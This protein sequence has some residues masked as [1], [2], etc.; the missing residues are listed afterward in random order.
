MST[1]EIIN[2]STGKIYPEFLPPTGEITSTLNITSPNNEYQITLEQ[3]ND[4][5]AYIFSYTTDDTEKPGNLQ[6]RNINDGN[7][8]LMTGNS[9][10]TMS[11]DNASNVLINTAPNNGNLAFTTEVEFQNGIVLSSNNT[12]TQI[13]QN[14]DNLSIVAGGTINFTTNNKT[15]II[16]TDGT[17]N[18]EGLTLGTSN[19]EVTYGT[20]DIQLVSTAGEFNVTDK[21]NTGQIYDTHFNPPPRAIYEQGTTQT[22]SSL[23]T[24]VYNYTP[25]TTGLYVFQFFVELG[26]TPNINSLTIGLNE[27]DSTEVINFSEVYYPTPVNPTDFNNS[28]NLSTGFIRLTGGTQYQFH[29]IPTTTWNIGSGGQYGYQIISF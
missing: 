22:A 26:A 17:V 14:T 7:I 19:C 9:S 8:E 24:T 12:D 4:G 28:V 29:I 6:I 11:S 13:I 1:A 27:Q 18:A 20:N 25:T 5:N 15:V 21:S 10:L 16:E 2:K 3:D 23:S